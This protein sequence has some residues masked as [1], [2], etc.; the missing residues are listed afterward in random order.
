MLVT[1]C[2]D[3]HCDHACEH[4]RADLVAIMIAAQPGVNAECIAAAS[5]AQTLELVSEVPQLF[6][7][8]KK[9]K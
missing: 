1:K 6:K 5:S 4:T 2:L 8:A 3:L 7:T 9:E